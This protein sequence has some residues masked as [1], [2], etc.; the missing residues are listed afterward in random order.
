MI[1]RGAPVQKNTWQN[2]PL[3]NSISHCHSNEPKKIINYFNGWLWKQLKT[4]FS[5]NVSPLITRNQNSISLTK[6]NVARRHLSSEFMAERGIQPLLRSKRFPMP[7]P[8]KKSKYSPLWFVFPLI[9]VKLFV[10]YWPFQLRLTQ[11]QISNTSRP[12]W[13]WCG[14]WWS[15]LTRLSPSRW[16]MELR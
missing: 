12:E 8:H 6:R 9:I 2:D 1:F 5:M 13:S 3:V 15:S 14:S 16:R 11:F 10:E 7:P 4:I